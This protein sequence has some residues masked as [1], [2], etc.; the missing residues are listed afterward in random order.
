MQTITRTRSNL[1]VA[2]V[3][4]V[5]F[6]LL[7][8]A[9]FVAGFWFRGTPA[10]ARVA[11][12]QGTESAVGNY[13]LLT[14]VQNLLNDHFL[15]QQ[16]DQKQLEYGAIR[17]LLSTLNDKY[18]F[19]VDPPVAH[20]ESDVLAGKY[21]GIG[22]Q[23]KRDESGNFVLYPFPNGPANKAGVKDGDILL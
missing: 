20:S 8:S 4:G 2:L 11:P 18:T 9:V 21:G 15:R 5:L 6:G 13:P 17:G 23:V 12:A 22:V 3:N 14:E 1:L 16:P 19:L 7:L 10:G